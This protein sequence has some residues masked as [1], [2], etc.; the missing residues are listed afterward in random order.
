MAQ[1]RRSMMCLLKTQR[2]C[3]FQLHYSNVCMYLL[4]ASIV[5]VHSILVAYICMHK[6]VSTLR[7]SNVETDLCILKV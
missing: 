5:L 6:S 1:S 3:N 2:K 7:E 4:F